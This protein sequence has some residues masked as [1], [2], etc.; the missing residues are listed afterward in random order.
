MGRTSVDLP[1][2]GRCRLTD[3]T[4]ILASGE[5]DALGDPIRK[6][7]KV[8]G[9]DVTFDAIGLAAVRLDK[10]GKVEALAAGG[11][12]TFKAGDTTIE[13]ATPADVALWK[14]GS[15]KWRG[16]LQGYEG[17]VPEALAKKTKNWQRLKIPQ[18]LPPRK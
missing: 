4:V 12:K 10:N 7:I 17:E 14:D 2:S 9:L 13:L 18:P 15:G 6:T 16:V 3:G 1:A 8:Q 5:Q 11:L